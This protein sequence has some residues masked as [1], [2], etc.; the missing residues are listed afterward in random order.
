MISKEIEKFVKNV[1]I[2]NNIYGSDHCPISIEINLNYPKKY[3]KI[4]S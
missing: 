3:L 2:L 1:D 4:K